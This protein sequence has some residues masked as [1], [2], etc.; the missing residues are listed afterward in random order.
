MAAIPETVTTAV[1][2]SGYKIQR[3]NRRQGGG[4]RTK[5]G[6]SRTEGRRDREEKKIDREEDK[7]CNIS[8]VSF[9][10]SLETPL[11]P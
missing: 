8:P 1:L 4:K 6:G 10:P 2:S 11:A 5:G 7:H 3:R 9:S